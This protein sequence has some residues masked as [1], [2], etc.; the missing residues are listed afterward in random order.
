MAKRQHLDIWRLN[1][2]SG[3]R[4]RLSYGDY[5]DANADEYTNQYT[6]VNANEHSNEYTNANEHGYEYPDANQYT[7]SHPNGDEY[8]NAD[9]YPG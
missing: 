9:Q 4:R 3:T 6:Y 7:N 8:A 5:P 2:L 1:F